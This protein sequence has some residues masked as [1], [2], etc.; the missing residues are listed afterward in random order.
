MTSDDGR[1]TLVLARATFNWNMGNVYGRNE[2]SPLS[3]DYSILGKVRPGLII[4]SKGRFR[5]RVTV[6]GTSCKNSG[7]EWE[8][9]TTCAIL[10]SRPDQCDD[11]ETLKGKNLFHDMVPWLFVE[12]STKTVI[13]TLSNTRKVSKMTGNIVVNSRR[14]NKWPNNCIPRIV[15]VWMR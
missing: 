7:G 8:V 6:E 3:E 10:P 11:V 2:D 4:P 13:L 9:P 5:I 12:D 1:W 14:L 15:K